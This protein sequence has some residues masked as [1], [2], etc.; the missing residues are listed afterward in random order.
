M[1]DLELAFQALNG[2]QETYDALW[3]YYRGKQPL[4]YTA[5]RLRDIFKNVDAY[6]A[7]N[8]CA[9]VIDAMK[10]RIELVEL[11]LEDTSTHD[12]LDTL[13]QENEMNLESDEVHT[14]ALVCGEAF[15]VVWPDAE[16]KPQAF[17][18]DPR[19]CHIFYEAD[20]P[21]RKRF[22]AKWWVGDDDRRYLTLYYPDHLEYYVS[23]GKAGNVH[24]ASAFVPLNEP[25]APNPYDE[26][27]VFHF[28]TQHTIISDLNDVVPI[29]DAINK[30]LT[31]MMVAAE[32][33]AFPQRW[34]ISSAGVHGKVKNAPNEIMDLPAA[35]DGMQP[36]SAGQFNIADLRQFFDAINNLV[37]AISAITRTPHHYFFNT[38]G[39]PSGEALIVME[40]GLNKKT[41]DRIDRFIP[42]W[43]RVGAFMLKIAGVVVNPLDIE[44]E[45]DEVATV[46]P[47][48]EAEI[49]QIKR[50]TGLLDDQL[51]VSQETILT[52]LGY[53]AEEEKR[54]K[55][56]ESGDM[57]E[58][59]LTAF[60]R[61]SVSEGVVRV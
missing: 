1:T 58:T 4:I 23:S 51:G 48:S 41:L 25:T 53:D 52:V 8:W 32:Y 14:A 54:L 40:S 6:F 55:E 7:E 36:T 34:I 37:S 60:D 43:R 42:T 2:K 13:W 31:D 3:N 26:I 49:E 29:Q 20:N 17:Y 27:P 16:G 50:Q 21:R 46:Q 33:G 28:R 15:V 56:T 59:M 35:E 39:V 44:P 9:V 5:K 45:F 47:R 38:G 12:V 11:K 24:T 30:L 57:A 61:D 10:E 19:L 18:N 22:A